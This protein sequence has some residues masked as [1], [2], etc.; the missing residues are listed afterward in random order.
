ML[1]EPRE[2]RFP[3]GMRVQALQDLF[4]D[5]THPGSEPG[6]LLVEVGDEGE[7]VN[8]GHHNEANAP[9]Y[10]VEFKGGKVLGVLEEEIAPFGT[11]EFE[12]VP[13][14]ELLAQALAIKAEAEAARVAATPEAS[15]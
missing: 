12:D 6:T 5:G 4:N 7:I 10:L 1:I 9:I 13:E 8:I 14:E 11:V 2:P 15:A 3:W